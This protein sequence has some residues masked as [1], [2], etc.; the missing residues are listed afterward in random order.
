MKWSDAIFGNQ[1]QLIWKPWLV[2]TMRFDGKYW[3]DDGRAE[4]ILVKMKTRLG[5]EWFVRPERLLYTSQ[6][7]MEAVEPFGST[8][9]VIAANTRARGQA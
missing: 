5:D 8:G 7:I 4:G 9:Q 2:D 3:V 6:M 1:Y